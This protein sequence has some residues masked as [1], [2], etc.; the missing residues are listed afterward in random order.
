MS[1]NGMSSDLA[2]EKLIKDFSP[3]EQFLA[4]E[5]RDV[6]REC[7]ARKTCYPPPAIIMSKKAIAG[8]IGGV[9]VIATLINIV[10]EVL[11]N[12]LGG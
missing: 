3:A 10:I 4:R 6:K 8:G 5:L 12:R 2:F 1:G 9:G 7:E 11:R